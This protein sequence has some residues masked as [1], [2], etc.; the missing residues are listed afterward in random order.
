MTIGEAVRLIREKAGETV[1][2]MAGILGVEGDYLSLVEGGG[3][4]PNAHL[5]DSVRRYYGYDPRALVAA[6]GLSGREEAVVLGWAAGRVVK[7]VAAGFGVSKER[8][9]Q[10]KNRALNKL[11][12]AAGVGGVA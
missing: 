1:W 7:D 5:P 9:R 3:Y 12:K 6:A 11:R 2:E 10:L 4:D 8:G